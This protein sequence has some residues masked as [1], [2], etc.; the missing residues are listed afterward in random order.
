MIRIVLFSFILIPLSFAAEP[1]Q[2]DTI[3]ASERIDI[4]DPVAKVNGN[5]IIRNV[6]ADA[7]DEA[8]GNS[9]VDPSTIPQEQFLFGAR[10][11]LN[12]IIMDQVV[13]VAKET[14]GVSDAEV[15][16]QIE[17]IRGRYPVES[18]LVAALA[19]ENT[20]LDELPSV[21]RRGLQHEK[22]LD[23]LVTDKIEVTDEDISSFYQANR[24]TFEIPAET[25]AS[26]I[27]F[28]VPEGAPESVRAAKE[29][30][31]SAAM[32]RAHDGEDFAELAK[33]LSEE[34]A[35]REKGGDMGFF[36]RDAMVPEFADVAFAV[37]PDHTSNVVRSRH[38][39]HIIRVT[40]RKAAVPIPLDEVRESIATQLAEEKRR[41]PRQA[42]LD[43]LMAAADIEVFL[44]DPE[45][46]PVDI[47]DSSPTGGSEEGD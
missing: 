42:G 21:V 15:Q 14:I 27:V 8:I 20:T 2:N 34:E 9:G 1:S 33:E 22:W 39:F 35:T 19:T 13:S 16:E 36:R 3:R 38:G 26:Q 5:P 7:I 45:P 31:A 4:P 11:I 30:A 41:A 10:A 43:A 28:L 37:P 44:P 40:D 25:R 29:K 18:E 24:A 32:E 46:I 17:I 23:S 6:L 12:D 47:A